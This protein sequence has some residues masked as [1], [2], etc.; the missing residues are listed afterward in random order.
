MK[1]GRHISVVLGGVLTIFAQ[2]SVADMTAKYQLDSPRGQSI[3]TIQYHDPQHVRLEMREGER[4]RLAVMIRRGDKVYAVGPGGEVMEMTGGLASALGGLFGG[5]SSRSD[6]SSS[7]MQFHDTGRNERVAGYTGRVY[8][9][10]GNGEQHDVVLT[11][12]RDLANLFQ[13][14]IDMNKLITHRSSADNTLAAIQQGSPGRHTG[15]LRFD[16][17]MRLLSVNKGPIAAAAFDLPGRAVDMAG[18][19]TGQSSQTMLERDSRDIATH[20]TEAAHQAVKQGVQNGIDEQIQ[21]GVNGLLQ[22][23]F[24][25]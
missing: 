1:P 20:S 8:R 16:H 12:D 25:R 11:Q 13:A 14:W 7:G 19:S 3:Q 6:S 21:R 2:M 4:G 22:G 9:Y 10:T 18:H 15:F 24:N 17:T 23:L 5:S